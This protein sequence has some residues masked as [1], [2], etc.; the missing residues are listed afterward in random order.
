MVASLSSLDLDFAFCA[1]LEL[2]F[3]PS[4]TMWFFCCSPKVAKTISSG[5]IPMIFLC[6]LPVSFG[7]HFSLHF[8]QYETE[9]NGQLCFE[10]LKSCETSKI[11]NQFG[12]GQSW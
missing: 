7:C 3:D 4:T 5:L 12:V 9:H 1:F 8:R 11:C 10:D 6:S 2:L